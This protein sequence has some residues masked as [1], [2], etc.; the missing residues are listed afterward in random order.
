MYQ[1]S[2]KLAAL[3]PFNLAHPVGWLTKKATK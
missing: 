1:N 3:V 2:L